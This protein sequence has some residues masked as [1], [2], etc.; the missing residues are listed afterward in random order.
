MQIASEAPV[1]YRT[2]SQQPRAWSMIATAW[3][4]A[5][6]RRRLIRYLAGADIKKKGTDTVL[7]NVWWVLDPLI[8]MAIYTFV[9]TVIFQRSIPDFPLYLMA[10]MVPFK[11]F[12]QTIADSVGTVVKGERLIKKIA[13]P[14]I[15]LP[16]AGSVS[17]VLSFIF[18]MIL[19]IPL[20]MFF[21]HGHHLSLL[22]LWI[23]VIAVVQYVFTLGISI[24]VSAFTV[25]YR[26]VG[27]IISHLLRLLFF[28]SPVLWSL[29]STAGRGADI[30]KA[31]GDTGYAIISLNPIAILLTQ[32]RHVIYG[33]VV[34]KP[35]GKALV[36]APPQPPDLYALLFL[37]I[38]GFMLLA[39][40]TWVFKRLE[41]AFSKVL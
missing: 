5:W 13:F 17:E 37:L 35:N 18:G 36:W 32:Y 30:R 39:F 10:A 3:Q 11:W 38:M 16:I 29:D 6:S 27:I 34:V 20:S 19:L 21:S 2:T 8:S 24:G 1:T 22:V 9:M 14:K 4:E 28:L 23:P 40:G 33:T 26:D 31:L 7:G 25:F 41:P 12:T 15:V